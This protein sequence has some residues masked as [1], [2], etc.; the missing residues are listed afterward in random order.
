MNSSSQQRLALV[1]P[2]LSDLI[3]Q[4]STLCLQEG[5]AI[6]VM[7]GLRTVEEQDALYAQG[8]TT[9]GKIVTN[10]QG[11]HSWHNF[12][13]AVDCAPVEPDGSIDWNAEHPQSKTMER[14][15]VSI[16]LTS[17]A[18]WI[19]IVDAPHFQ[20]TGRFSENAPDDEVRQLYAAGGL[21]AVWDE[22]SK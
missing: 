15:G 3:F 17:G 12:G 21:Q 22:V 14:L 2:G 7:Q 4:L 18:N 20:L 10:A 13:L 1:Y 16:G 6:T 8:R 5:F 19:R 9:P 11:G